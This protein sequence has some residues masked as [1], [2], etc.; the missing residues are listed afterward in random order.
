MWLYRYV[1]RP[2]RRGFI[3]HQYLVTALLFLLCVETLIHINNY[4]VKRPS[5]PLDEPFIRG[6]QEPNVQAARE[7][8]AI[9]ML[10]RNRELEGAVKSVKSI[11]KQFNRWFK[12][13]IVFLNDEPWDQAF[14]DAL[15]QVA[16]GNVTFDT[17]PKDM[18]GFPDWMDQNEAR[19]KM[20]QQEERG[21]MYAGLES[22]HHMCRFNSG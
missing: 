8:A 11:E 1:A 5:R 17:I 9:V 3:R 13:P 12:Y 20:K 19:K 7:N 14:I 16:S 4:D 6:C 15:T 21:V 2:L 22:Y 18:W 10:A